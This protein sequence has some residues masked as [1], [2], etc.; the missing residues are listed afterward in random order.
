MPFTREEIDAE[1]ASLVVPDLTSL[2][3]NNRVTG[4]ASHNA[5]RTPAENRLQFKAWRSRQ[6]KARLKELRRAEYLRNREKKLAYQRAYRART[7]R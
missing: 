6:P 7:G 1:F 3:C 4:W 2:P 5:Q